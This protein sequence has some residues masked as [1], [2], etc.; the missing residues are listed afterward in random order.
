MAKKSLI[1]IDGVYR[2][3]KKSF[4]TVDETYHKIKKAFLTIGG[5]YRPC[6]S[7]GLEY[8]GK[9]TPLSAA[10]NNP[11]ATNNGTYA[12]LAG[13]DKGASFG[14]GTNRY[15]ALVDAYDKRLTKI[16]A[17]SFTTSRTMVGSGRLKNLA[18]FAGGS[19]GTQTKL[20]DMFAVDSSLTLTKATSNLQQNCDNLSLASVDNKII[21]G[22]G[23]SESGSYSRIIDVYDDSL[24]KISGAT[25]FSTLTGRKPA[26]SLGNYAVFPG[27]M[28]SSSSGTFYEE[29]IDIYDASLTR[30]N[31]GVQL[32]DK[33]GFHAG[34]PIKGKAIIG[35]GTNSSGKLA[36]V[37]VLDESLTL[38]SGVD[39]L[40]Q[41]RSA[42]PAVTI[43]D[44]CALFIGGEIKNGQSAVVDAYDAS[45]THTVAQ[46][47]SE[48]RN[49]H[50]AA[51]IGAFALVG[52]GNTPSTTYEASVEA[53]TYS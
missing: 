20:N 1:T 38:I 33:R 17:P 46:P 30:I 42:F 51:A 3:N 32:T 22:G 16:N 43:E 34:T 52:G 37:E 9:I 4:L 10:V 41:A 12:F 48:G 19:R 2:R 45:L 31:T 50:A 7:S 29:V 40:S 35:G 28:G 8:Y 18:C 44:E 15:S 25:V 5:V 53:Y 39:S 36:S 26:F 6:W 14:S 49:V 24:T 47:L 27:G 23:I 11:T 13:G 21:L